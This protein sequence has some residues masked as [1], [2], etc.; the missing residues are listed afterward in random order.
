MKRRKRFAIV[1]GVAAAGVMALG[2]QT[3]AAATY[4]TTVTITQDGGAPGVLIHGYVISAP[5]VGKCE[6]GRRVALFKQRPGTDR[7]LGTVRG[8]AARPGAVWGK[9][10]DRAKAGWRVY[11]RASEVRLNGL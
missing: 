9:G 3:A 10:V 8:E 6:V 4:K 7:L 1:I 2:A 11:A 5:H